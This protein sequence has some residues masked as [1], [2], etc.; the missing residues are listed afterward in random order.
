MWDKRFAVYIMANA[1]PT[2]CVGI[3]N[4]LIRRVYEHKNNLNPRSFTAKY[5]LHRL[6]Y[7]ELCENSFSAIIR[8]K[9]IKNMSR[10]GKIEL[11]SQ[12]KPTFS[13]LY[14]DIVETIPD[15]PE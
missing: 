10:Q 12:S 9:Q 4:N 7:Y 6:V 8:E 14:E 2:L 5:Y 15:K 13:D 3:T 1:R 11:I